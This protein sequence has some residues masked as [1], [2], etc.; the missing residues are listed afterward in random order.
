MQTEGQVIY[1][2]Y[3]DND[4]VEHGHREQDQER[5]D[6]TMEREREISSS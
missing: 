5:R 1:V 2:N 4:A 3:V 6:S